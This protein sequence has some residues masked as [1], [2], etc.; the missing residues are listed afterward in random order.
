MNGIQK[1]VGSIPIVSTRLSLDAIRV[2]G[3]FFIEMSG[4]RFNQSKWTTLPNTKNQSAENADWFFVLQRISP[5]LFC[6]EV[7]PLPSCR[8]KSCGALSVTFMKR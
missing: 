7:S 8:S 5:H 3:S 6:G 2:P 4:S 1:V